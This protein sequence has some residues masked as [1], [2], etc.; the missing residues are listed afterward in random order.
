MHFHYFFI[1]QCYGDTTPVFLQRPV[2]YKHPTQQ[3]QEKRQHT[4]VALDCFASGIVKSSFFICSATSVVS[5]KTV[6]IDLVIE[7]E[8]DIT[9]TT[10]I[11]LG[12]KIRYCLT[13]LSK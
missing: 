4:L 1:L 6:R 5:L 12:R 9:Q 7:E 10:T 3:K 2:E 13:T 8:G 11:S